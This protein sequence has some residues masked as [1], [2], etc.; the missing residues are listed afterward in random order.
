MFLEGTIRVYDCGDM[1][2]SKYSEDGFYKVEGKLA[3]VNKEW[4]SDVKLDKGD[5][6][7]KIKVTDYKGNLN[8][9]I[10]SLA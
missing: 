8:L 5:Q 4:I 9:R 7:V 1:E 3:G 2:K 6:D 10:V